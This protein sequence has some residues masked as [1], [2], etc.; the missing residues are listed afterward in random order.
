MKKTLF[1]G[2]LLA[3]LG[4]ANISAKTQSIQEPETAQCYRQVCTVITVKEGNCNVTYKVTTTY[5][6]CFVVCEKRTEIKR[7]C[8]GGGNG[9]FTK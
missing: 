7:D 8:S 6:L 4:T 1:A 5:F 2:L 3:T 9:N